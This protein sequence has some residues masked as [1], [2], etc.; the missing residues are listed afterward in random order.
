MEHITFWTTFYRIGKFSL[1]NFWRNRLL[2]IAATLVMTIT[3]L[4]ISIFTFLNL[5]V[6]ATISAINQKIDLAIYFNEDT[7]E[8][9]ILI[10]Q[11]QVKML[12]DVKS[13]EYIDKA[14]ALVRWQA[15]QI[16]PRLREAVTEKDN[17]LPRSLEIK[18]THPD[19]LETVAAYFD[20]PDIKPLVRKTSLHENK[21]TI[22]RLIN[23]TKF[24]KKVGIAAGGF[25]LIV[26]VLIIF[27][28]IRLTIFT[29]R[30][31]I[32]IMKLVGA[33]NSFVRWPFILEGILYGIL[34]TIFSVLLIWLG[35]RFMSPVVN[36]YLGEVMTTW[37]GTLLGF[38]QAQIFWIILLQLFVAIIIGS[39]CSLVAMR[40]HLKV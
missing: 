25:F 17:P 20:A 15:R 19:K 23:M 6:S 1:L 30:D 32:E 12:P 2:S 11:E 36:K 35:F 13:V 21:T 28:T 16:D 27:N 8:E 3:L 18:V 31:E 26:S 9:S 29:R 14:K 40:K 38:F 22:Q 10:L 5:F 24:I 4:I 33:T 7:K 34:G 39:A 37:G